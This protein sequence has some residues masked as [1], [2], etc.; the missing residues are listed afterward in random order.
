M[1]LNKIQLKSDLKSVFV[2]LQTYDGSE[3]KTK[4]NAQEYI[5]SQFANIIHNY[6][7]SADVQTNVSTA[8]HQFRRYK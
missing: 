8:V 4:E 6:I 3:G 1:A 7:K 5:A 2:E